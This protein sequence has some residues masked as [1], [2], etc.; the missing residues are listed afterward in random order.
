MPK[1][2]DIMFNF[3]DADLR[4]YLGESVME[5]LVEW[6]PPGRNTFTKARLIELISTIHGTDL[7]KNKDFRRDL[8]L[9]S[10]SEQ[11]L[12]KIRDACLT[13][14]EKQE[15]DSR[16]IVD[17][18]VN[19]AWGNNKTTRYLLN[20]WE[21]P[22]TILEKRQSDD[23]SSNCVNAYEER[24]F[25]L[26][27][28]QFYI[29]QRVLTVLNS[30]IP[31]QRMLVHMPTGTGK[32]KTS[33]HIITHYINFSLEKKGLVLWI[34]HTT[35]LLMQ[36]YVT[37]ENVWYHL[38]NG[39][40]KAYKIW[41]SMDLPDGEEPLD[42]IAFC[43]ISKL[44]SIAKSHPS[45]FE[46]IKKNC[47]LIVF[48]EAHR[49]SA[50]ETKKIIEEIMTMKNG[51]ENRNMMGLSA[52]PGRTTEESYA[53]DD[54]P[55][56]FDNRLIGIDAE[57]LNRVN[58]GPLKALNTT[59]ETNIIKYFQQRRILAEL[60]VERLEYIDKFSKEELERL[61]KDLAVI[62]NKNRVEY[63]SQ[64]L[65]VLATNKT[66]NLEILRRLRRL[67]EE[68][69]PTIVFACNVLHAKMLSSML[70]VEN[71]PNSLVIGDMEPT[72]RKNAISQFKDRESKVNII[73][74]YDVLTTGFDS[75]NIKCVFITRPTKSVVLYSQ[76]IGR[77]LRGPLMGGNKECLLIDVKDNIESFDSDE[78]FS[79]FDAY[80]K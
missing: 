13:G 14:T 4:K 80:W 31:L 75:T 8:L 60:T 41:G 68:G 19:K 57:T 65:H 63:S 61:K 55:N 18:L 64:Q 47:R 36:A 27:D 29:K 74:N 42:G 32:T 46:R 54:L 78:A 35:E 34:A 7:L 69:I 43:G 6:L 66:R 45:E 11:S 50:Q 62:R 26:L 21:I 16:K 12:Y 48:D 70:K 71:I 52:T 53:N 15:N 23:L 24:F 17:Y 73:I 67:N 76:M 37:F 56:M 72:E 39:D 33:M 22:E 3:S 10:N 59:A 51:Y 49:A 20:L 58:L 9:A 79:H 5:T 2:T 77:G 28:Y 25:E 44:M 30:G 1:Y 38:G 40:I